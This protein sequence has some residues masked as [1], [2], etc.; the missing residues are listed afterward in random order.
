MGSTVEI[1]F[2]SDSLLLLHVAP[3]SFR[4]VIEI[5]FRVPPAFVYPD[6]ASLPVY[7]VRAV[8]LIYGSFAR[9]FKLWPF[10]FS[11]KSTKSA[12]STSYPPNRSCKVKDTLLILLK[13]ILIWILGFITI[14][15]TSLLTRS[16]NK[17]L[18]KASINSC[19]DVTCLCNSAHLTPGASK[20]TVEQG[21]PS[22]HC[23]VTCHS[24]T[25]CIQDRVLGSCNVDLKTE[26][27][28]GPTVCLGNVLSCSSD[29]RL[30]YKQA[31]KAHMDVLIK[32][33]KGKKI[34]NAYGCGIN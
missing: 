4:P 17:Q 1:A 20:S 10:W 28:K 14:I 29:I 31:S 12:R 18:Q 5:H 33:G 7:H 13:H 6:K 25:A 26:L 27:F 9:C 32:G 21:P 15:N 2:E 23:K 16:L 24:K 11:A 22:S 19:N 34:I 3:W 30:W 8:M